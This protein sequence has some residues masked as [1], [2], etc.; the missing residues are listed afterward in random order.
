MGTLLIRGGRVIDPASATDRTADVAVMGEC[1][2]A[3]GPKLDASK[4]ERVIDA[5]GLLVV[6]GLIDPHVHLREPGAEHKE[7][8]ASGSQAAVFG[9]FTTVCC[10]PNTSPALDT[11]EMIGFVAHR[12]RET[13]ACRVFTVGAAT[14]GRRGEEV[15]E[16]VLMAR[17]GAAG[18]SDDGDC[19]A[20]AGVMARVLGAVAGT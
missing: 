3:I 8:L 4:A 7:T 13:A 2:A 5:A 10:M 6:P 9:G 1:I 11:P 15:A 16:I 18:F 14:K 17:A 12:A 20:S 19:I